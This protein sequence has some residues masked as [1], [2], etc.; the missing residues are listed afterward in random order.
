MATS[1]GP[2]GMR[3]TRP[4]TADRAA[5]ATVAASDGQAT[6]G[7]QTTGAAA[8]GVVAVQRLATRVAA[9][10]TM[11]TRRYCM[12]A[13]RRT[14]APKPSA[15][16]VMTVA[17]PGK[18]PHIAVVPGR[19]RR[20]ASSQPSATL[21]AITDRTP[22]RKVGQSCAISLIVE[23]R[24]TRAIRQPTIAWAPRKRRGG[25][26]TSTSAAVSAAA[27]ASDPSISAAGRR[28]S[29]SPPTSAA[30]SAT[31]I[32]QRAASLTRLRKPRS[33]ER[34]RP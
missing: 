31:R 8:C 28:R 26:W 1:I 27:A 21:A 7:N 13:T 30:V 3:K 24:T 34:P 29:S 19:T 2:A 22:P 25:T 4:I 10:A 15:I 6:G 17:A 14:S 32:A 11:T 23:G 9:T 5:S 33:C 18:A 20:R 16:S 12:R